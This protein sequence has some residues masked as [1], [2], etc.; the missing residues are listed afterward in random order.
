MWQKR[1]GHEHDHID[2]RTGV[3]V[4]RLHNPVTDG[5]HLLHI[6]LGVDSCAHCKRPFPK[7]DLGAVDPKALVEDALAML[8]AN[9]DAVISYAEKH[10]IPVKLGPNASIV[11]E[12]HKVLQHGESKLL[13]PPRK[14]K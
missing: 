13:M 3:H 10:G 12:G 6:L 11:P 9:H 4:V 7:D 14:A 1:A 5:E 2:G 8:K